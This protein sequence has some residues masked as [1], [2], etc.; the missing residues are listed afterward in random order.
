M[1]TVSGLISRPN[2][3]FKQPEFKLGQKKKAQQLFKYLQKK[4]YRHQEDLGY[5]S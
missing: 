1:K 2:L 3:A 5:V 4:Q